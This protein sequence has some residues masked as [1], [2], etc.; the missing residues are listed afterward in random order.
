[1]NWMDFFGKIAFLIFLELYCNVAFSSNEYAGEHSICPC[2]LSGWCEVTSTW[3]FEGSENSEGHFHRRSSWCC[4]WYWA[5]KNCFALNC[6]PP[7]AHLSGRR[8]SIF[9][10]FRRHHGENI[11]ALSANSKLQL[12]YRVFGREIKA[13]TIFWGLRNRTSIYI[14]IE[15]LK[16]IH[17]PN[18]S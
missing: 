11:W 5:E 8:P 9:G 10:W 14:L 7:Y 4:N 17:L 18:S 12:D 16:F 1:M 6:P 2:Y 3:S 13:G 15:I